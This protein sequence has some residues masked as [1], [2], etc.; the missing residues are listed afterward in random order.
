MNRLRIV[1]YSI[2]VAVLPAFVGFLHS[3]IDILRE[4][5]GPAAWALTVRTGLISAAMIL[6]FSRLAYVQKHRPV[7]HL[8]AVVVLG[9]AFWVLLSVALLALLSVSM[10]NLGGVTLGSVL[11]ALGF[12]VASA[13]LG[14]FVGYLFK[15]L[16]PGAHQ[17]PS[18]EH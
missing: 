14:G 3:V 4:A 7:L 15:L 5:P 9:W 2:A 13:I 18:K 10:P 16:R 8:G 12:I 1:G 6:V 17:I 11:R